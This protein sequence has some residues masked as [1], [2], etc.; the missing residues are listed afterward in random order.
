ME[1]S[2]NL[3]DVHFLE[4]R[5]YDHN[6]EQIGLDDGQEYAFF[7]RDDHQSIRAGIAGWM[8]AGS[9]YVRLL[10]VHKD[11]RGQQ[12]GTKLMQ[13]VE[14]EA[15]RRG[16]QQIVVESFSF[17]A[18]GFYQKLGFETYAVLEDHPRGHRHHYFYKRIG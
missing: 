15:L 1:I 3:E 6:V 16:C 5:L 18:P 8:W 7:V 11:L 17:Q 2:P 12:V 10:W 13:S 4:D 9:C 14:R